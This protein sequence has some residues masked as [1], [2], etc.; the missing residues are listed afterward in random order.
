MPPS[1]VLQR[2]NRDL[3]DQQLSEQ[4]FITMV[5]VLFNHSRRHAAI[6]P[7]RPS[8]SAVCAVRWTAEVCGKS[9]V[10][11]WASSTSSIRVEQQQLRP[12]DKVLLYTDGTDH[13][14]FEGEPAGVKS[15]LAWVA[16]NRARPIT[17]M[18]DRLAVELFGQSQQKDDLTVLG[19]EM[20]QPG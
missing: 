19:L 6:R 4:P 9:R 17:E 1:E 10:V 2:L 15:V 5:Y 13:A 14:Q 12:G 20:V 3:I 11:C 18:V 7:L 8:V 16:R